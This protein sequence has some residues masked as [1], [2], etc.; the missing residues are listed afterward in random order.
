ME[1]KKKEC[2]HSKQNKSISGDMNP[3]N[4][5]SPKVIHVDGYPRKGKLRKKEK[6]VTRLEENQSDR[7]ANEGSGR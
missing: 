7:E 6:N 2:S 4:C 3:P 5:L 1:L